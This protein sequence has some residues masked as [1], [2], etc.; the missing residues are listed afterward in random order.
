MRSSP[1]RV[2]LRNS[3]PEICRT[4]TRTYAARDLS[5][6]P[7]RRLL[8]GRCQRALRLPNPVKFARKL[9]NVWRLAHGSDD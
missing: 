7:K 3:G 2:P 5:N 6:T 1:A 4:S 9:G 8:C